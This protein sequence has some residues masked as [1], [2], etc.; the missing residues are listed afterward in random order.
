MKTMFALAILLAA[1]SYV[2][3]AEGRVADETLAKMGLASLD[4]LSDGEGQ[5]IRGQGSN[6]FTYANTLSSTAVPG[7]FNITQATAINPNVS[8]AAGNSYSAG[9]YNPYFLPPMS[10]AVGARGFAFAAR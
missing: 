6:Y 9:Y 10:N 4:T 2:I 1:T 5:A 7:A 8:G 3:A